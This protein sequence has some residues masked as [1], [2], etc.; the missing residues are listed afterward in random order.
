MKRYA[1]ILH[2]HVIAIETGE[3]APVY[4]PTRN[5]DAIFA[6]ECGDDVVVNMTYDQETGTFSAPAPIPEP[7]PI[8]D[9]DDTEIEKLKK[10]NRLLKAQTEMQAEQMTFLEECILEMAEIVYA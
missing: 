7:E 8:P 4:A 5:G 1:M 2:N 10:D 6:V 9:A 3:I